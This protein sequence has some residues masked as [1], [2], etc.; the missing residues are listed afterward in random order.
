MLAAELAAG[1]EG[2]T[3]TPL[4]VWLAVKKVMDET[5]GFYVGHNR[6]SIVDRVRM[7]RKEMDFG[8]KF[9][10]VECLHNVMGNSD[11]P[12]LHYHASFPDKSNP[13]QLMQLMVF[14]N[15]TFIPLLK[16]KKLEIFVD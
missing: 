1:V 10:D 9:R 14:A 15:P 16:S 4:Q 13:K 3:M 7:S 6:Q 12:F 11:C 5:H 8:D 2:R